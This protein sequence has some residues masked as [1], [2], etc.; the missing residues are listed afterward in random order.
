MPTKQNISLDQIQSKAVYHW[1][2]FFWTSIFEKWV[3]W[4]NKLEELELDKTDFKIYKK[5]KMCKNSQDNFVKE[6]RNGD[7]P[8]MI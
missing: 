7:L 3:L 8:Y 4:S 2:V 5:N 6:Q 1:S